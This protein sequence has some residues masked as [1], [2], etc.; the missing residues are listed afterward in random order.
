MNI[1]I[2][3]TGNAATILGRKFR[4]AGHIMLQ[5]AGRNAASSSSLANEWDCG[6]TNNWDTV[7]THADVYIIAVS[8]Q[9]I[10]EVSQHLKLPGRVVAHT[11][12][13]VSKEILKPVTPHYG[14]FYPLQSLSKDLKELPDIPIFYDGSDTLALKTLE[15]LALSIAPDNVTQAGDEARL[16]LHVAAVIVSNFTNHLYSMAENFCAREGL[17]FSQLLPLIEETASRIKEMAPAKA[18][19]GPAIRQDEVTIHKHLELLDSH[20][21]IKKLY[22][23][24]TESI[25]TTSSI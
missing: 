5:V 16:K 18:Q 1:V 9:A 15:Q 21:G 14:V 13:S 23:F 7:V 24:L 10:I 22:R 25:A 6:F 8:D 17:D 19:T 4:K 3:G 20:P 11:A 12:A 2:L